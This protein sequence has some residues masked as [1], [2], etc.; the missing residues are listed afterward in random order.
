M[1]NIF[2]K[3]PNIIMILL[4]GAR[5]NALEKV[6][7]FA[8]LKKES[9]FFSKMITYAPYTIASLHASFSGIY[10]NKNGVDGYYK[11]FSFKKEECFTLPQYLKEEGYY[12]ECD[13]I[14]G[15][16]VPSGGFDK[17]AVHDEFND[18]LVVRHCEILKRIKS[19]Q[20]FFLFLD[21]S[22]LHTNLVQNVIKK[23]TDF[24]ESYFKNKDKNFESYIK[25]LDV[26]AV[27]LKSVLDEIKNL[28]LMENS[29]V[30]VFNDHGTSVGDRFGERNY[31]IFLYDYTIRCFLYMIGKNIPKNI[32]VKSL[33]R[34]IDMMPTI[35]DIVGIKEKKDCMKMQGKS[36]LPMISGK[37]ENR[38][39]YSETGGL[40]GPNPSPQ[41]HNIK[42]IRT[43]KWKLI[44]NETTG[45][46]EL[47][48]LEQDKE[49]K[50]NLIG[51]SKETENYLWGLLESEQ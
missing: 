34:S 48:D 42:S 11:A 12:T 46:K 9:V 30:L 2:K 38:I 41:K 3:K 19:K 29:V 7:Y 1:L 44:F 18:D 33:I 8:E 26:S 15:D 31:G 45:A 28:G 50:N 40:G 17:V 4:D 13:L 16:T 32:E 37:E 36:L 6:P 5:C 47:Y 10:G 21:Y 35:L 24:D 25:Y 39:A 14:R 22:K 43:G 27:Y 20:P 51:K 23:H 49:E